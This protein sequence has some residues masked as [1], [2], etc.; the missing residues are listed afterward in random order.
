MIEAIVTYTILTIVFIYII[1]DRFELGI[2][3]KL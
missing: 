3:D 1:D 2:I